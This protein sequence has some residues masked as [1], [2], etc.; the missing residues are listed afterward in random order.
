M[1]QCRVCSGAGL[2]PCP[3]C[4]G[5]EDPMPLP[6]PDLG[7]VPPPGAYFRHDHQTRVFSDVQRGRSF[8]ALGQAL[9]LPLC[10][11]DLRVR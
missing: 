2:I 1:A 6:D 8:S 4:A 5:W 10:L 7:P 9:G 11:C 3:L